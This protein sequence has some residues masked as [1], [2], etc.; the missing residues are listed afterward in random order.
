MS[1]Y[2]TLAKREYTVNVEVILDDDKL[3]IL[4][5]GD[6]ILEIDIGYLYLLYLENKY[7]DSFK[8]LQAGEGGKQ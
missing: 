4:V 2:L 7:G 8:K 6:K 3:V 1:G 5:S